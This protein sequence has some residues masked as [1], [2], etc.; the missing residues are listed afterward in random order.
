LAKLCDGKIIGID[1]DQKSLDKLNEK[2]QK[3]GLSKRVFT[4]KCSL[5]NLD[6]P[7]DNFD[8]IWAEGSINIVGFEKSLKELR[9]LLR[10]DGFLVIHDG[11][12]E[13]STK[14][15]KTSELGYKLLNHFRLPED[16]WW[17]H[18]FEPL[19]QLIKEFK[20]KAKNGKIQTILERFQN[21][22][23]QYKINPKKNVSAFYIF[24][25][26]QTIGI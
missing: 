25:K 23:D 15:K 8:I 5:L 26:N 13:I 3:E 2:I 21:E 1:I 7:N 18:Y 22:V 20:E 12:K 24:Q 9:N 16:A 4:K 17:I 14:L 19:D 10:K 6:F 11:V